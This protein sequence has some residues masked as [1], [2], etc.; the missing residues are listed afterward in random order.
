MQEKA[1]RY[2]DPTPLIEHRKYCILFSLLQYL[3]YQ[4]PLVAATDVVSSE[5]GNSQEI[6]FMCQ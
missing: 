1:N 4:Q 3:F 2:L 6:F 5:N